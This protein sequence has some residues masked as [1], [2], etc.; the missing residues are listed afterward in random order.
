MIGKSPVKQHD[1]FRPLLVEFIDMSNELVQLSQQM[2]WKEF[3]DEFSGHYST[4]GTPAK[5]IRLM[6]GLLILKQLYSLGDETL[7]P[8]WMMTPYYQFFCGEVHFQHKSPC[9][10]SDLVHFRKRIGPKGIEKI[11]RQSI[12]IHGKASEEEEICVDTTAQEKNIT[13]PTDVKLQVKIIKQ[14]KKICEKEGIVQ[15]QSYTRTTK[16][17]LLRSRFSHHP[18]RMKDARKA[19]RKIKTIAWRLVREL[20]RETASKY[21]EKITLFKKVLAQKRNDSNKI[22]S[23][24]EP[25]VACIAKGKSHKPYEFGSK[26]SLAITKNSGIIV[27]ALNF[28]GNPHD[29]QTITSTLKQHEQLTGQRAKIAIVDRGYPSKVIDGTQVIKPDNGIL[30]SSYQKQK[31]RRQ[32]RRRAAIEPIIGHAKK[33]FGMVRNYLKGVKGDQINVMMAA[34]AF[35]FRKWMNKIIRFLLSILENRQ[36]LLQQIGIENWTSLKMSC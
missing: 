3:E 26:A 20:E 6:V 36:V 18:K 15:R 35:N 25:D 33:R 11:F 34:A 32:F 29:S 21:I 30:K 2:N 8:A 23:L 19:Q 17:L 16:K 14:C 9:D 24:H 5:P 13:F 22:Y 27:A 1:L 12:V 4:T 7:I 31:A 28:C 10:P